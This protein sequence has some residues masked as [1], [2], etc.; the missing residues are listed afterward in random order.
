VVSQTLGNHVYQSK[1]VHEWSASIVENVLKALHGQ[2]KPFKYVGMLNR[3]NFHAQDLWLS[4]FFYVSVTCIIM[5]KNGA[6]LHTASTC[7]WDTKT[8][9]GLQCKR[10][11]QLN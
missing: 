7:Y 4:D 1:K 2:Q 10:I 3:F 5:Q 11:K 6:G 9:G 8:D